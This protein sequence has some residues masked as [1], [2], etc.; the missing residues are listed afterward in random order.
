MVVWFI[1]SV[2][3]FELEESV[4]C[5]G[6]LERWRSFNLKPPTG[7]YRDWCNYLRLIDFPGKLFFFLNKS[8]IEF[9]CG[10]NQDVL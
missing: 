5:I 4:G 8:R 9:N 10:N 7:E 3:L 6:I 1:V 2:P